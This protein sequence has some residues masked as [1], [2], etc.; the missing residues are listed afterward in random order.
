ML[1]QFLQKLTENCYFLISTAIKGKEF[2]ENPS[3]AAL[4]HTQ[5]AALLFLA[6]LILPGCSQCPPAGSCPLLQDSSGYICRK[7]QRT[8][9]WMFYI[10][11]W[12]N[13]EYFASLRNPKFAPEFTEV[14]QWSICS[15]P[16]GQQSDKQSWRSQCL[17]LEKPLIEDRIKRLGMKLP[18]WHFPQPRNTL[19]RGSG[20]ARH[21]PLCHVQGG[22]P[23]RAPGTQNKP[24]CA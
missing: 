13:S 14:H 10:T 18:H 4:W 2:Q 16:K 23:S 8:T 1:P 12:G 21:Q 19:L 3:V 17:G 6:L 11:T 24:Q 7:T 15:P 22:L 20:T 5:P 9:G